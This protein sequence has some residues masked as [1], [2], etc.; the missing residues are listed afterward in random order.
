MS[1]AASTS[2]TDKLLCHWCGKNKRLPG[3]SRCRSCQNKVNERQRELRAQ[4]RAAGLC[5]CGR[6]VPR[7][8]RADC[9][10][11]ASEI[12]K[13]ANVTERNRSAA[14][15]CRCGAVPVDG[16]KMCADC[17]AWS[18][19]KHQ[20]LRRRVLEHYGLKCACCPEDIYEFLEIDHIAGGGNDHRRLIGSGIYRWL[21][22]NNFPPGFQ[23]LCSNCN[24]AKFKYGICPH[25]RAKI[26]R[27]S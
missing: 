12:S 13:S 15:L 27:E 9:E 25:Q 17:R 21:V 4:R 10:L 20:R 2:S 8:G 11:C 16:G 1:V 3:A 7:E 23:T 22:R 5:K 26:A 18:N 24:R 6:A 19:A 14:G